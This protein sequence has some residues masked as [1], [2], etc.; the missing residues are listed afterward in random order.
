[1]EAA[2]NIFHAHEVLPLDPGRGF[3]RG[4]FFSTFRKRLYES[5]EGFHA[6]DDDDVEGVI[7]GECSEKYVFG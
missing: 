1:M 4:L 6:C 3:D 7:S 5:D 2:K